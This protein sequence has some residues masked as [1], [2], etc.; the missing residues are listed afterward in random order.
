[1]TASPLT[2]RLLIAAAVV[3]PFVVWYEPQWSEPDAND[4][5]NYFDGLEVGCKEVTVGKLSAPV[6]SSDSAVIVCHY[7]FA[8]GTWINS[9]HF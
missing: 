4:S 3:A 9:R 7:R 1:M 6:G 8:D 5:L 2:L